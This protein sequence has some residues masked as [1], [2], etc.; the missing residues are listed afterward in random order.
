LDGFLGDIQSNV[1]D[2]ALIGVVL[3]TASSSAFKIL[4]A[5]PRL[6][7]QVL[8]GIGSMR[9]AYRRNLAPHL[10]APGQG[11]WRYLFGQWIKLKDTRTRDQALITSK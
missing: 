9:W 3:S 6:P 8:A 7:D 1:D 5:S 11:W 10:T 4:R 2:A